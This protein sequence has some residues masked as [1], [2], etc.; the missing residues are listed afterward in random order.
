[1]WCHFGR[2]QFFTNISLGLG[3]PFICRLTIVTQ[4]HLRVL[5][6]SCRT[7]LQIDGNKVVAGGHLRINQLL[8]QAQTFMAAQRKAP[9]QRTVLQVN[10]GFVMPVFR[11][12]AIQS[13]NFRIHRFIPVNQV[14]FLQPAGIFKQDIGF[15]RRLRN[16][17]VFAGKRQA[18]VNIGQRVHRH[19]LVDAFL[20]TA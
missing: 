10:T 11:R 4:R 18:G 8:T 20:V 6:Q 19:I 3:I 13:R 2:K 15:S 5:R 14:I 1:M 16:D 17:L 9:A 12:D 7:V